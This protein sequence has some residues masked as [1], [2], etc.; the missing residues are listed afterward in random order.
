MIMTTTTERFFISVASELR[1]VG[2][3]PE[4]ADL[5]CPNGEIVR[6]R[7]YLQATNARG[8]RRRHGFFVTPE[9][10]EASIEAAPPVLLWD[11]DRPEYGSLA[12]QEYGEEDDIE[13]ERRM[14]EAEEFGF[15]TRFMLF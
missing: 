13:S 2:Y 6:E 3:N 12:Y 14:L 11:E 10:A 8:D 4:A 1:V 5:D 7:F 15:D 9:E